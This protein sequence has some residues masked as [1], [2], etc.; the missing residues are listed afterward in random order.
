MKRNREYEINCRHWRA[1]E[2]VVAVLTKYDGSLTDD[3]LL[4]VCV[5]I[6]NYICKFYSIVG[7]FKSEILYGKFAYGYV[8][9]EN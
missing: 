9:Y 1:A 4:Q 6:K 3:V 7:C 2:N 8:F 5:V